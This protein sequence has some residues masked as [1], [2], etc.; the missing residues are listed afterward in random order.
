MHDEFYI[1]FRSVN[2]MCHSDCQSK[3]KQPNIFFMI[4]KLSIFFQFSIST[5]QSYHKYYIYWNIECTTKSTHDVYALQNIESKHLIPKYYIILM[6]NVSSLFFGITLYNFRR[7]LKLQQKW[8]AWY[9]LATFT[10]Q[11]CLARERYV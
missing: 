3:P 7:Q 11:N 6:N 10:F 9:E 5:W 2:S 1:R 8:I 4:W